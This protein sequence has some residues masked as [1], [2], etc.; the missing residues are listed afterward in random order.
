MNV[1]ETFDPNAA[2]PTSALKAF[3]VNPD[4]TVPRERIFTGRLISDLKLSA[5]TADYHLQ[6]YEPDVDR[7]GH[8]VVFEDEYVVT[9]QQLKVAYGETAEWEIRK[10]LL[11]PDVRY[12]DYLGL[13]RI[14]GQN[15]DVEVEGL[16]GGVIV[17]IPEVNEG[18]ILIGTQFLYTDIFILS[19]I[20]FQLIVRQNTTV[21]I[22]KTLINKLTC[23][24][25]EK[26]ITLR[27]SCF[28]A[29][30]CPE[31]LLALMG[32]RSRYSSSWRL[33]VVRYISTANNP[34]LKNEETDEEQRQLAD[35]IKL[36]L[37]Q[38]N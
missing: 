26:T 19:A 4:M 16:Q 9:Y 27:K 7:D 24:P 3:L 6:H 2:I 28:V 36:N 20:A 17:I 8:D 30:K 10:R 29:T 37:A 31:K 23:S 15:P 32:L 21:E 35:L 18:G 25:E 11:R 34:L 38:L 13:E 1:W 22:A 5:A 12:R 33:N 14:P